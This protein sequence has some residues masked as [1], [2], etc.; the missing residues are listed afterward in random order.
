MGIQE[1][2]SKDLTIAR[3]EK[4]LIKEDLSFLLGEVMA[5]GKNKG[6]RDSTD[7]EVVQVL[8]DLLKNEYL[9][10]SER[11]LYN[12]YLPAQLEDFDLLFRIKEEC[13]NYSAINGIIPKENKSLGIINKIFKNKYDGQYDP[14]KLSEFSKQVLGL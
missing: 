5:P 4:L 9:K 7:G 12:S 6:N 11:E 10:E 2:I 8:R 3:K 1:Q 13:Q 14:K